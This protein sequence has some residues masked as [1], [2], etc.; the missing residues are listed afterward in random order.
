ML[1]SLKWATKR[2]Y[3]SADVESL[4]FKL[5]LIAGDKGAVVVRTKNEKNKE[6]ACTGGDWLEKR[7][8]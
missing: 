1:S 8:R 5:Q 7:W 3:I 2:E 6:Y 4:P